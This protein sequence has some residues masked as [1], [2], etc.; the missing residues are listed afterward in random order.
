MSGREQKN[1]CIKRESKNTEN[2]IKI[3]NKG[4]CF[5]YFKPKSP[6]KTYLDLF[7]FFRTGN[8]KHLNF[9]VLDEL[10]LIISEQAKFPLKKLKRI[11][12]MFVRNNKLQLVNNGKVIK[13]QFFYFG[14]REIFSDKV[15]KIY[16]KLKILFEMEKSSILVRKIIKFFLKYF[17]N[18][19]N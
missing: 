15:T 18:Y 7:S 11:P 16:E 2:E 9:G 19:K 6:I 17:S 3:Y 14:G 1:T 5:F 4:Y 12:T 10:F 13:L 8:L